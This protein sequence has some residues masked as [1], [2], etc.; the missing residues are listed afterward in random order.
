M[1]YKELLGL[2]NKY[3]VAYDFENAILLANL[4]DLVNDIETVLTEIQDIEDNIES[5]TMVSDWRRYRDPYIPEEVVKVLGL[6]AAYNILYDLLNWDYDIFHSE[7]KTYE[8]WG[9]SDLKPKAR[10]LLLDQFEKVETD[11]HNN[12]RVVV[13]AKSEDYFVDSDLTHFID[14]HYFRSEVKAVKEAVGLSKVIEAH[15]SI[16]AITILNDIGGDDSYQQYKLTCA[17]DMLHWDRYFADCDKA[18]LQNLLVSRCLEAVAS[19]KAF[20]EQAK[21]FIRNYELTFEAL[22]AAEKCVADFLDGLE[23]TYSDVEYWIDHLEANE[24]EEETKDLR[25]M[26]KKPA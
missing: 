18:E 14:I 1:D 5:D 15:P 2:A 10:E 23:K 24:W 9:W 13:N 11:D 4:D 3:G 17:L 7:A 22:E 21:E 19:F 8:F 6:D 26:L 25:A 16:S 12:F 20:N